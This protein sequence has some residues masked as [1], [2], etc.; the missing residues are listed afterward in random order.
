MIKALHLYQNIITIE[1]YFNYPQFNLFK[2]SKENF[3]GL[4]EKIV[5]YLFA[6]IDY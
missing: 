3:F 5:I 2:G 1:H 6:I 4:N